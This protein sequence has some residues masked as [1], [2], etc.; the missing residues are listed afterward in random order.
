M[1]RLVVLTIVMITGAVACGLP[2]D[3]EFEAISP[4]Q[5]ESGLSESPTTSTTTMPTTTTS[6]QSTTTIDGTTTTS[7]A[8]TT[9]T[10]ATELVDIYFPSGRG[11]ASIP[12]TM[13]ANP[14]LTQ[15]MGAIL[16]GPPAG[17]LGI[18]LRRVL[19]DG[20][21][22]RDIPVANAAGVATV[23]LPEG[24][25]DSLDAIDQRL[26]FGQIV[27]TLTNCC[28]GIGQVVFTL[29]GQPTRVYRGNGE[30]TEPGEAVSSDD[31]TNLLTGATGTPAT[32]APPTTMPPTTMPSTA[33]PSTT[34]PPIAIR[35]TTTTSTTT[36]TTSPPPSST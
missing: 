18:T 6:P 14:S 29:D 28:A 32:T 24:I 11:L 33:V 16:E 15:V 10:I 3:G 1:R 27:A 25:F 4:E 19:P 36:A 5:D 34:V 30:T 20:L 23:D 12:R 21:R 35:A 9:T 17:E 2:R 31:Y 8:Q 13:P 26:L 22:E 7:V